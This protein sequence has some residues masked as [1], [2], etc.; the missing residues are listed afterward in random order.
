MWNVLIAIQSRMVTCDSSCSLE[1]SGVSHPSH[2]NCVES[3]CKTL[4]RNTTS[5]QLL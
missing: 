2:Y 4:K 3:K 1:I 5:V